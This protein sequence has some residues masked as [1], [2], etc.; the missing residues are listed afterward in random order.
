MSGE[1]DLP[2]PRRRLPLSRR[3]RLR[4][5]VRRAQLAVAVAV[6]GLSVAEIAD[7]DTG[8]QALDLALLAFGV[9]TGLSAAMEGVPRCPTCTR[10]VADPKM[11]R[12]VETCPYC[13]G[14]L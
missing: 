12:G 7:A 9:Y 2:R 4:H 6:V 1:E 3:W 10:P 11:H 14:Y 5:R 13:G 8:N